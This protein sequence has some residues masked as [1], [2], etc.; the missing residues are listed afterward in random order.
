M[1]RF[2]DVVDTYFAASNSTHQPISRACLII[3]RFIRFP[4][5]LHSPGN[6]SNPPCCLLGCWLGG[7]MRKSANWSIG[8][9]RTLAPCAN[10]YS[11]IPSRLVWHS[12]VCRNSLLVV[13]GKHSPTVFKPA[14]A[15]ELKMT[16]CV[17]LS[18]PKYSKIFIRVYATGDAEIDD[19]DDDD[20][21]ECGFPT[22]DVTPVKRWA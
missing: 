21:D 17:L 2:N 20:D 5:K 15:P 4:L 8:T 19:D 16:L 14:V 7:D 10:A 1:L 13:Q 18:T 22:T 6:A 9:A 3:V 12:V 11:R